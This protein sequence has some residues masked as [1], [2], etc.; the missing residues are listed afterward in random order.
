MI[1]KCLK[2]DASL[3]EKDRKLLMITI[4]FRKIVNFLYTR[5]NQPSKFGTENW[6]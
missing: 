6:K 3:Q 2:K 1:K 5:P 4:E